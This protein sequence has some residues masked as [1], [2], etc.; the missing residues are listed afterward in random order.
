[1][2]GTDEARRRKT[3]ALLG[4]GYAL[5]ADDGSDIALALEA[6]RV[7]PDARRDAFLA[8]L[9]AAKRLV[10]A[11]GLLLRALRRWL[12]RVRSVS[13]GEA[14]IA[15]PAVRQSLRA[16]DLYVIEPRAFH[17]DHERLVGRYDGLREESGCEMNLDL[18]RIAIPA[19]QARWLLEGRQVTRI[20]VEDVNDAAAF[21]FA[22][23]P[24]LHVAD[25]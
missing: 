8:P 1:M 6:G 21:S 4:E 7:V 10:V 9:R 20:V 11:E 19:S 15:R 18:Q 14:L 23:A 24:V 25:L 16:G 5:A 17:G 3:L 13:L 2:L 12:P 22:P